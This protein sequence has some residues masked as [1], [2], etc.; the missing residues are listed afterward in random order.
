VGAV[1]DGNPGLQAALRAQWLERINE[2]FRRRTKNLGLIAGRG[3]RPSVVIWIVAERPD[4]VAPN[5]WLGPDTKAAGLPQS[6]VKYPARLS[7]EY[8]F[9]F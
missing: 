1:I 9:I 2:E 5:R 4:R 7:K 6:G 8:T 3:L